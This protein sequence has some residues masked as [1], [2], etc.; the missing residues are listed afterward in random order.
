M[1]IFPDLMVKVLVTGS[2]GVGK[3]TLLQ[4]LV[5]QLGPDQCAGFTTQ[6]LR[7]QEGARI[8]LSTKF[9]RNFKIFREILY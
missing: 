3:T 4:H 6:E 8:E 7:D 2:P 1:F 5:T 9:S